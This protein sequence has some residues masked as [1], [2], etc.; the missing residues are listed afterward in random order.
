MG[1]V[2]M[3][4]SARPEKAKIQGEAQ[5]NQT[6]T[7]GGNSSADSDD[8]KGSDCASWNARRPSHDKAFP[9][10]KLP[11]IPFSGVPGAQSENTERSMFAVDRENKRDSPVTIMP[12]AA[13]RVRSHRSPCRDRLSR[14]PNSD[15]GEPGFRARIGPCNSR[16][17]LTC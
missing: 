7:I 2:L 10:S 1:A 12:L 4:S 6:R 14:D 13:E 17:V 8:P 5:S 9:G 3:S 11:V 16:S 15:A